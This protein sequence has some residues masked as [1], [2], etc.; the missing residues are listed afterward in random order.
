MLLKLSANIDATDNAEKNPIH[1]AA[2]YGEVGCVKLLGEYAP[3]SI[4]YSSE[5]GKSPLHFAAMN[6]HK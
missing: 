4:N 6:G 1:V 2:E 3:G 5:T